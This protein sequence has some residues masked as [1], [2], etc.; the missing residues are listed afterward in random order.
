MKEVKSGLWRKS[1]LIVFLFL[2]L[3]LI[4]PNTTPAMAQTTQ[5][6]NVHWCMGGLG[7]AGCP[8]NHNDLSYGCRKAFP[9]LYQPTDGSPHYQRG[10]TLWLGNDSTATTVNYS[11]ALYKVAFYEPSFP[12]NELAKYTDDIDTFYT[13]LAEQMKG[14][15]HIFEYSAGLIPSNPAGMNPAPV[16]IL[17]QFSVNVKHIEPEIIPDKLGAYNFIVSVTVKVPTDS[18][19]SEEIVL[20]DLG[21]TFHVTE[22][23]IEDPGDEDPGDET[24]SDDNPADENP[25]D[26]NPGDENPVD[27][28]PDD[29]TIGGGDNINT[30][31]GNTNPPSNNQSSN[32]SG[33]SNRPVQISIINNNQTPRAPSPQGEIQNAEI[34]NAENTP[35]IVAN[36]PNIPA[37]KPSSENGNISNNSPSDIGG[38]SIDNDLAR[39]NDIGL[40]LTPLSAVALGASLAIAA[41]FALSILPDIKILRWYNK[42]KRASWK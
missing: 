36:S 27:E 12:L 15:V 42:K 29:D 18:N 41:G 6:D 40:K 11:H 10:Q 3:F 37:N 34:N 21:W 22:A 28:N 13:A 23:E 32:S 17:S 14:Y 30:P 7:E 38:L 20:P 39:G 1:Q 25:S 9:E 8:A 26:D 19:T 35:D 16:G 33:A 31:G 2:A 4:L 24:P 5:L